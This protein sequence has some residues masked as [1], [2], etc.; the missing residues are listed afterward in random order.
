MRI[1]F[2]LLTSFFML[3]GPAGAYSCN[4]SYVQLDTVIAVGNEFD[5]YATLC[6]GGGV[7]G[8]V[9][10]A[11]GSTFDLAFAFY[12]SCPSPMNFSFFTPS[13]TSDST[14]A[15]LFVLDVGPYQQAPFFAD[16]V[17]G[18]FDPLYTFT[19]L[20]CATSTAQCGRPHQ[21]C[22]SLR[23]RS[24][25][26]PDSARVFGVEGNGNPSAGCSMDADMLI[27]FSAY[28]PGG[29]CCNDTTPPVPVCATTPAFLNA[30][31]RGTIAPANADSGSFDNCAL[32]SL[33]LSQD[34]FTCADLGIQMV[35]LYVTDQTGNIDSCQ[36]TV[37]VQ[38]FVAPVIFCP[39][40][41]TT[42]SQGPGCGT[43][44]NFNL[45]TGSDNCGGFS[46][47]SSTP[48]GSY[49]P[50]GVT[51]VNYFAFDSSNNMGFCGFDITVLPPAPIVSNFNFSQVGN[52]S[53]SFLDQSSAGAIFRTW[54]FGD[55]NT[56]L[57]QNPAHQYVA[58]GSYTVCLIA[59]D[60][61]TSD[62]LCQNIAVVGVESAFA[63]PEVQL[64][65]NPGEGWVNLK[66]AGRGRE[67]LGLRVLDPMGRTL[68][69][70]PEVHTNAGGLL[71]VDLQHL[72]A[73][74]YFL[75]VVGN[76]W[77]ATKRMVIQ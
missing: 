69:R 19:P 67:M 6:I 2:C 50:V 34:T 66:I 76:G 16:H 59:A 11:D 29:I 18:Y 5:I 26:V 15:T 14:G 1:V 31:G 55:G 20:S 9:Q 51:T 13:I 65:P 60:S 38:E 36:A 77:S 37:D 41:F 63:R 64:Y 23:F 40:N 33:Y 72:S 61:C 43:P 45:P 54:D 70:L 48:P 24:N 42:Q 68:T 22:Y 62:T 21:Q 12:T 7:Q 4:L 30:A 3:F 39:Q 25:I 56:S 17:I 46:L 58:A 57:V 52:L 44:V 32:A 8:A 28:P 53:Y 47:T 74:I 71:T 10:G 49:F 73:G 75:E 27:D 35:T